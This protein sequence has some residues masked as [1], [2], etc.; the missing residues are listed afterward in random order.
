MMASY[1]LAEVIHQVACSRYRSGSVTRD[2]LSFEH[3][4]N[5]RPG[6]SAPA[7]A[8]RKSQP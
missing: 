6:V 2:E 5:L 4:M 3:S 7:A 8:D 1:A